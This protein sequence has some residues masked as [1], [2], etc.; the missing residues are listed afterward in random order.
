VGGKKLTSKPHHPDV[1]ASERQDKARGIAKGG[2]FVHGKPA[3]NNA[4]DCKSDG[5]DQKRTFNV[6]AGHRRRSLGQPFLLFAQ[7]VDRFYPSCYVGL[8]FPRRSSTG[9]AVV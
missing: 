3:R 6:L 4:D 5:R 1:A 7:D 8:R 2:A 9:S